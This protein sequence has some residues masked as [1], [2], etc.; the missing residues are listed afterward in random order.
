MSL[1]G[2]RRVHRIHVE[3]EESGRRSRVLADLIWRGSNPAEADATYAQRMRDE[4]VVVEAARLSA[5]DV[6]KLD[7]ILGA[8]NSEQAHDH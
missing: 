1:P 6:V 3:A 7:A 8:M 5:H 4:T 2:I